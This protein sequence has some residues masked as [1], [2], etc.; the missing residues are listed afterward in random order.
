[1]TDANDAERVGRVRDALAALGHE[2]QVL[3]TGASTHT[4]EMAAAAAGC[5]LGQIVKTL[6]AYVSGAPLF[7]LVPG[8][9]RLDDRLLAARF[10]VGRKQVK[11]ADAAQVLELTGYPVGG[12]SPFGTPTTLPVL[13][14]ASF[15]R[16]DVLWIAGGTAAAILPIRRADLVRY[17]DAEYAQIS[18]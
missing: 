12:V 10:G 18:T 13:I 11:L 15:E 6:V 5:E 7:A 1:M 9:R 4:A 14:D 17:V 3:D 8:D 2:A 16:F